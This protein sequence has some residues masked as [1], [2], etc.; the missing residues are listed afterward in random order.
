MAKT[1]K[2]PF[3]ISARTARLIGRQNFP[4]SEGAIIELVK[5]SYDADASICI[6]VFDNRFSVVPEKITPK[7]YVEFGKE[8][9][10]I[11]KYY[12]FDESQGEYVYRENNSI[13]AKDPD[14]TKHEKNSLQDFFRLKTKIYVMD[15][16]EGMTNKIIEDY[17]MT[18]GTNNKE[19]DIFTQNK[20]VKTGAKGIG[21]FAL[22]KLG[23]VAEMLTKPNPKVHKVR[24]NDLAFLWQVDWESFDGDKKTLDEVEA[25]LI[26]IEIPNFESEIENVLP[27][28]AKLIEGMKLKSFKTGTKIEIGELRD[29]WDEY[30]TDRLFAN[31]EVLIPPREEREFEIY[32]FTTNN[33]QKYGRVSPSICDDYDYKLEAHVDENGVANITIYRNEF[34]VN[35]FQDEIFES[36]VLQEKNTQRPSLK[37]GNIL[38]ITLLSS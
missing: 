15:N 36:E 24:S 31:L 13:S 20:R 14:T 21:R 19:V 26:D 38:L 7:E 27:E 1:K 28:S 11:A 17:W 6:V 18:I 33:P 34:D 23:D 2:L 5:N 9:K 32:L 10:L 37:R 30:L 22:D 29:L 12:S 35:L 16:G 3:K 4:N 8:L 25:D